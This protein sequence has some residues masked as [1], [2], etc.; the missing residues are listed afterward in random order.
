M[1]RRAPTIIALDNKDVDSHLERIFLRYSLTTSFE[2]LRLD[3]DESSNDLLMDHFPMSSGASSDPSDV[4]IDESGLGQGGCSFYEDASSPKYKDVASTGANSLPASATKSCL[5]SPDLSQQR[6]SLQNA[7]SSEVYPCTVD[8][9][10]LKVKFALS[11]QEFDQHRGTCRL[12]EGIDSPRRRAITRA[13][14]IDAPVA[15]DSSSS[16]PQISFLS[17]AVSSSPPTANLPLPHRDLS[18]APT[19][20]EA[21]VAERTVSSVSAANS[22][23]GDRGSQAK[24]VT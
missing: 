20:D 5:R 4:D 24:L 1:I 11:P 6:F 22:V 21:V 7:I 15:I 19:S 3:E 13:G 23:G 9:P 2:Q 8:P 10:R 14:H 12:P 17:C 16:T 18:L